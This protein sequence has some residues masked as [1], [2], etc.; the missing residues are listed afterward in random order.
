MLFGLLL[1][2]WLLARRKWDYAAGPWRDD[3]G[4][5]AL[6]A[7][8][9]LYVG[10]MSL[11][12]HKQ[13]RFL[14]AAFP[15]LNTLAAFAFVA[16]A[17]QRHLSTRRIGATGGLLLVIQLAT[18]LPFHPYYFSYFNPLAGGGP[19][20]A[21]LTRIGWGEGM[22]QVAAY[23]QSLDKP[24]A[25]LVA[26]RFYRYLVGFEGKTINLDRDGDWTRADKIVFYI[27]QTQ[28]MLDPSPGV[29]RYFEQHVPPE[30]V[31]TINGIDY[32]T[33]Y[34]NPIQ[35]P[36]DP[37]V[38]Q[39][40]GELSLL[41]YRWQATPDAGGLALIWQN[42]NRQAGP[43]GVRLWATNDLHSP[44]QPCQTRP[45]FEVAAQTPGEVVESDCHLS[46]ANL[47]PGLYDLQVGRRQPGGPWQIVD[48]ASGWSAIE[49]R[50]DGSL[51]RVEPEVVFTRLAAETVPASA[52]RL[53]HT[54]ANRVRLLAYEL[55]PQQLQPGQPLT[56]T[57]YWQ[58]MRVLEQEAHVSVQAFL[59]NNERV[60]LV[61]GPPFGNERPTTSWRPGEVLPDVWRLDLSPDIPRPA[62]LRIDV[63]LFLP[64]TLVAL[65]IQNLAGE[66]MPGAIAHVRLEPESWPSYR[67]DYPTNFIFG[68]AISLVGYDVQK[69]PASRK[70]D[71]AL[72]WDSLTA[73]ADDEPY[74]A[75]LH[76]L[77]TEGAL[78]AQSDV[79]PAAGLFP[80]SAW[81]PGDLVLSRHQLELPAD[82]PQPANY[83]LLAGLYHP[84]DGAR[85][86]ARRAAN[87]EPLLNDAAPI[88]YIT[89]P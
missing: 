10:G 44:W 74:T 84:S 39:I 73:L 1:G 55:W 23:L 4:L 28:R 57:L 80:T 9:L 20:A 67:G 53:E 19:V 61:N 64:D 46:P 15:A 78:I 63:G 69:I 14:M 59:N 25:L 54:Y 32:A 7:Y 29:I 34:P 62:L 75:F 2:L 5:W 50:A 24:E 6:L 65:P 58:A 70:L 36:A 79:P 76:L 52:P 47:P 22:D 66:A 40:E 49:T 43:V 77:N 3:N 11:G 30:K 45:G 85:L 13:D 41:G 35:Y 89:W 48:F 56:L 42:F 82:A 21:R 26:S 86:T 87:N 37:V 68:G 16:L 88:G 51:H 27:Q 60:A 71:V 81:Q 8:V 72:Y 18:A 38:D 33:V 83:K 17:Q 31:V 12:S